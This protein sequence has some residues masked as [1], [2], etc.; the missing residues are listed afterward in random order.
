MRESSEVTI[1]NE[2]TEQLTM[3]RNYVRQV[4]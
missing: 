3:T 2:H 4:D 1:S